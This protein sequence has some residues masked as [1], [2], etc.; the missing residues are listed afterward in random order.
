MLVLLL[1]PMPMLQQLLAPEPVGALALLPPLRRQLEP[2]E[3]PV[4]ELRKMM[5][6]MSMLKLLL[7]RMR[8]LET[9]ELIVMPRLSLLPLP[10]VPLV[11]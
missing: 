3:L 9:P 10:L 7:R 6:R 2:M 4:P 5:L 11:A 1:L 8:L